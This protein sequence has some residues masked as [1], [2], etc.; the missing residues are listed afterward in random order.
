MEKVTLENASVKHLERYIEILRDVI[1]KK[2]E[3]RFAQEMAWY[4]T[5]C[6]FHY[7]DYVNFNGNDGLLQIVGGGSAKTNQ[8]INQL[9][10]AKAV[11]AN[12]TGGNS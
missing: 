5:Y 2:R 1:M 4:Y 3:L 9:I 12:L 8:C 6:T 10:N 11:L 7:Y